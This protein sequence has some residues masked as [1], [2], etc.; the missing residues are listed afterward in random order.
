MGRTKFRTRKAFIGRKRMASKRRVRK[1]VFGEERRDDGL[2]T[3]VELVEDTVD[4]GQKK[5]ASARK[6]SVFGIEIE[7]ADNSIKAA[8][9]GEADDCF[10]IVQKSVIAD[11]M[12]QPWVCRE[13]DHIMQYL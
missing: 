7:D 11:L 1:E 13:R 5:S 10:I 4:R 12:Q 3:T 9:G 8:E 2:N 6:L